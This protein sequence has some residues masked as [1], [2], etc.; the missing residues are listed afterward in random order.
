MKTV[1]NQEIKTLKYVESQS[2]RNDTLDNI[3]Y[4]FLD[5]IKNRETNNT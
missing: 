1:K 5:K 2:V 3:S 4:D